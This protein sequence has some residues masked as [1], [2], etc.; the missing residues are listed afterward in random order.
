MKPGGATSTAAMKSAA[1]RWA[2]ITWAMASGA[3]RAGLADCMAAGLV[4]SPLAASLG[5]L[6]SIAGGS[7]AGSAP[8]AWAFL[9]A[10][11]TRSAISLRIIEVSPIRFD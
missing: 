4:K 11:V 3:M 9:I 1:G 6:I 7:N 5:R 10:C 2:A 8:A